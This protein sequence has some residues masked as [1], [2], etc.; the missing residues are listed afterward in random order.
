MGD[1]PRVEQVRKDIVAFDSRCFN[2]LPVVAP[3]V[4][5]PGSLRFVIDDHTGSAIAGQCEKLNLLRQAE[6][7]DQSKHNKCKH[8]RPCV[9]VCS[10]SHRDH[11]FLFV[12]AS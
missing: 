6:R 7:G 8:P 2:A 11:G 10:F 1:L 12:L 4:S 5:D 9:F 3:T